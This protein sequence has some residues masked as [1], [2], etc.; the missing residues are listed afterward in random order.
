M[1]KVCQ[2]NYGVLIDLALVEFDHGNDISPIVFSR[3]FNFGMHGA[4]A[5]RIFPPN[6]AGQPLKGINE[7]FAQLLA[8]VT[9][10][11]DEVLTS[12]KGHRKRN[13]IAALSRVIAP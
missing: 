10:Y 9:A 8:T 11:L 4:I 7:P 1:G 3:M 5:R 12:H 13:W 6:F 2:P